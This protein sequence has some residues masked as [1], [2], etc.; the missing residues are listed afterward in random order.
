MTMKTSIAERLLSVLAVSVVSILLVTIGMAVYVSSARAQETSTGTQAQYKLDFS[1]E[2]SPAQKGSNTVRVKITDSAG[3]PITGANVRVTFFMA[4]M[5]SMN[6]PAMKTTITASEK[7]NETYEGK[8]DLGSA[9]MWQVTINATKGGH[10]IATK[11]LTI[12][13]MGGM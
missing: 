8:G 1:T 2:P 3:K 11:K 4:A 9:G 7:D 6:M 5:P 12:K 10:T 13:A